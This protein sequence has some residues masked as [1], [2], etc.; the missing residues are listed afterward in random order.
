MMAGLLT[1]VDQLRKQSFELENQS[2]DAQ[3]FSHEVLNAMKLADMY[4]DIQPLPYVLPLDA[5]AGFT[6]A[7]DRSK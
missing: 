2:A 3:L 1:K 6:S 5:L 4:A 7:R